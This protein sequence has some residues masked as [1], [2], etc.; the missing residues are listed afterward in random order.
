MNKTKKTTKGWMKPQE[1]A[2]H[3]DLFPHHPSLTPPSSS[4]S[5][6]YRRYHPRDHPRY[7]NFGSGRTT[8]AY[9]LSEY[10]I[11]ES[12][13]KNGCYSQGKIVLEY[14]EEKGNS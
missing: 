2:P 7:K 4:P 9:T 12:D 14:K 10:T 1:G 3:I 5:T 6:Q 11:K 8:D 13:P